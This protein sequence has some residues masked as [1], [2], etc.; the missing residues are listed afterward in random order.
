MDP[1]ELRRQAGQ[2]VT[3]ARALAKAA[4]DA[5]RAMSKEETEKFDRLHDEAE[6]KLTEA[7]RLERSELLAHDIEDEP[8]PPEARGG[9]DPE[10]PADD[11]AE[12]RRSRPPQPGTP[13]EQRRRGEPT[14]AVMIGG[15][16]YRSHARA[17]EGYGAAFRHRLA[18]RQM[19]ANLLSGY[20]EEVR[21]TIQSDLFTGAGAL[22]PPMQFVRDLIKFVDDAVFIRGLATRHTVTEAQSLGVPT[23]D[24]DPTDP[25]WTSELETGDEGEITVGRRELY[26]HPLAKRVKVSRK[27][28][29][30]VSMIDRVVRERLGY[31]FEVALEKAYLTGSG[32][33]Q[34]LGVF[35]PSDDGIPTS[36]DVECGT[37]S[38]IT[39]DKMIDVKHTLKPQYWMRPGTRWV[40][41]RELLKRARK[42]KDGDGRYLWA[43][44]LEGGMPNTFLDVPYVVSEFAPS[45]FTGDAYVAVIGDF[46]FYWIADALGL[47]IDVVD[48]LYAETNQVGF[49]GRF[50]SDGQPVLAE[51][52]VRAQLAS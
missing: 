26:P 24:A 46:G 38:D 36:R 20:P 23:F 39:V 43:A 12:G 25:E 30:M 29:R 28:R 6:G 19:D 45:T 5:K 27:T 21:A 44:T 17:A 52:F 34:P 13:P 41:S 10:D 48:Q 18:G 49:I 3:E 16:D 35:E 14:G 4:A 42:L 2:L 1:K 15:V 50:E 8:E 9:G 22:S 40:F 7:R 31:K 11:P 33:Q 51:A 32:A 47:E 37:S